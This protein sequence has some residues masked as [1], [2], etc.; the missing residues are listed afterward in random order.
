LDI[1]NANRVG[2]FRRRNQKNVEHAPSPYLYRP[3]I[4]RLVAEM[5]G[6]DKILF[7]SDYPLLPP[8]RYLKE[9][10]AAGL[11]EEW[12]EMILGGNLAWLMGI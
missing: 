11:S 9:M 2:V 8:S 3:E 7:G 5:V 6:P 12:Q 10:E 1:G 4:Y